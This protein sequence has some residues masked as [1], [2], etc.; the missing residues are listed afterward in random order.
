MSNR[1]TKLKNENTRLRSLLTEQQERTRASLERAKDYYQ[2]GPKIGQVHM[3]HD[4]QLHALQIHRAGLSGGAVNV[5]VLSP[6]P[7]RL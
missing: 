5:I 6:F 3:L 2:N 7:G 4:G 1:M